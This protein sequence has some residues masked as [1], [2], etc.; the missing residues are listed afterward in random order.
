MIY[1]KV[2]HISE[3]ETFPFFYSSVLFPVVFNLFGF[4]PTKTQYC[5]DFGGRYGL[6]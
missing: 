5:H 4:F 3:N 2:N 1:R 6:G